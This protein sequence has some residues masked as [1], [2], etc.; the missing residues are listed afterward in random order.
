MRWASLQLLYVLS[1]T[2]LILTF[3]FIVK[4][5]RIVFLLIFD[6]NNYNNFIVA[7]G[8]KKSDETVLKKL[9]IG[10]VICLSEVLRNL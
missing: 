8:F 3:N 7:G 4:D 2:L 1:L 6:S 9:N 5:M 10:E